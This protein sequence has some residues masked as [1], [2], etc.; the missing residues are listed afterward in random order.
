MHPNSPDLYSY[1]VRT[2]VAS[3]PRQN[4]SVLLEKSLDNIDDNTLKIC[5]R[6]YQ[7]KVSQSYHSK[8]KLNLVFFH[9]IGMNKGLW[10]YHIDKLFKFFNS[11]QDNGNLHLNVVCAFDAV[12]H[13]D[14]AQLNKN[15]LGYI[16]DWRDS[17]KDVIKVLIEDESATF[18]ETENKISIM[19]GHSMGGFVTLYSAYLSPGLFDSCIV[20]NPVSHVHPNE[21]TERDIQFKKWYESNYMKDDFEI[22]NASNWYNEIEAYFKKNSFFRKFHSIV[23]ANMLEDEL[24]KEIKQSPNEAYSKIKLNTTVASQ[25]YTYWGMNKSVSCG[26]P[27][28][29]EI[30]IPIFHIVSE[31][32]NSSAEARRYLRNR[33]QQVVHGIDFPN[34]KH[35]LN[36]EDPDSLIKLFI[37]IL[38]E[39]DVIYSNMTLVDEKYLVKK[40]GKN[41]REVL[42]DARLDSIIK[43]GATAPKL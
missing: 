8:T 18:V 27:T 22:Q 20:V 38:Q 37:L 3:F 40:Y 10:H 34:A 28:F 17:S 26:M 9:G 24:P 19:I 13:A 36:G 30:E 25:L 5:Y 42:S 31:F 29:A 35:L 7:G 21:Y 14:S 39:R 12:N 23:L 6:R 2:A 41:Y 33:L 15:K 43:Y 32:D 16:Y 11:G 4:G 1:E